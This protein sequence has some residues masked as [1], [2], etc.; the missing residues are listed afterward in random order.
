METG[1]DPLSKMENIL[2]VVARHDDFR[3]RQSPLS[4]YGHAIRQ[5]PTYL[6]A[7]LSEA[8]A[9][10]RWFVFYACSEE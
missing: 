9:K 1:K 2:K 6:L 10:A 5:V 4:A 3:K 7:S 8:V